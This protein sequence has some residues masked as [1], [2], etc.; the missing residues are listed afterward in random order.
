MKIYTRTGDQGSTS[1]FG[2][3]SVSKDNI[4]VEAYGTIDELNSFL[5]LMIDELVDQDIKRFNQK[6]QHV[7]FNLGS[8]VATVDERFLDKIP[9][10]RS[11]DILA[12]ENE[13]DQMELT[14]PKM[15][16]FVLPSGHRQVSLAHVCRT[17]CR[18]AERC[19]VRLA[20]V[21]VVNDQIKTS[22]IFLNRL[23]DYFFVLSRKLTQ[24][25][26]V[27]EVIWKKDTIL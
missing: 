9:S 15:T 6:I 20:H 1:L 4:R 27:N 23:S 17:V 13:I 11:D 12:L 10:M 21:E 8:V 26:Q 18:R 5:G 19:L 3:D 2:G 14:L 24:L 22:I 7:L 16:N 25:N